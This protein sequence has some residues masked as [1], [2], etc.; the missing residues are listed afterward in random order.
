[1]AGGSFMQA[2]NNRRLRRQANNMTLD[3]SEYDALNNSLQRQD[4]NGQAMR[5]VRAAGIGYDQGQYEQEQAMRLA[6]GASRNS[7]SVLMQEA[8]QRG[9]EQSAT[10]YMGRR[11]QLGDI[12]MQQRMG[13]AQGVT[14]A[15]LG[16]LNAKSALLGQAAQQTNQM[17]Q[18][19]ADLG[20]AGVGAGVEQY[21][22]AGSSGG[23]RPQATGPQ[24]GYRPPS[25]AVGS[26]SSALSATPSAM[27]RMNNPYANPISASQMSAFDAFSA[28]P[29]VANG[30]KNQ[31]MRLYSPLNMYKE[32]GGY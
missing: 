4:I 3:T 23:F 31:K 8:R 5:D 32:N 29:S 19:F 28:P 30:Y 24:L 21:L 18:G 9:G 17:W 2:R 22:G 10:A 15:R 25:S 11:D 13:V 1:M 20:A 27:N 26:A 7:N 6:G 12:N 16:L 14:G